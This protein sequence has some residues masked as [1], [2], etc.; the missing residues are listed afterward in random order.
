MPERPTTT[1]GARGRGR[2]AT[3][4]PSGRPMS[5]KQAERKKK[6]AERRRALQLRALVVVG[7]VLALWGTWAAVSG[8]QLF[9]IKDIEVVGSTRLSADEVIALAALDPGETLL[10][11]DGG[12][13][14]ARLKS[15]PWIADAHLSRRIPSTLRIDVK[16]RVPAAV[17]D[18]GTTFWFVE[19]SG[20]VLAE[21]IASSATVVPVI[22]DVPDFV[23]EPG[24]E[25]E[26]EA[27]RNAL[28]VLGG[29]TDELRASVRTVSAPLVS[30]TALLTA[31][32]VE[33]MVG[34]AV[35]MEEKSVLIADILAAQGDRVVFIDV[36]SIERPISRGLGE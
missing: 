4:P 31:S 24:T 33:I 25:S 13:V 26:S 21:S 17:V 19:S 8:S 11:V 32:G 9:E 35:N 1:N 15:N 14:A 10:R 20:R 2:K 3:T 6:Q 23:A 22:R 12:E 7:A 29:L 28:R 27:L 5:P 36:R 30:E 16:E 34:E 18:T